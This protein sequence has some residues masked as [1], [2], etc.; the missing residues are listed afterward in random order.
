MDTDLPTAMADVPGQSVVDMGEQGCA[1]E[2][3]MEIVKLV[4]AKHI[5]SQFVRTT[6][7]SKLLTAIGESFMK[8]VPKKEDIVSLE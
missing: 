5:L 4:R 6:W 2:D 1:H 7:K 3:G 8:H